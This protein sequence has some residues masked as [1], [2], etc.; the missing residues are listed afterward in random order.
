M[1]RGELNLTRLGAG[2][3]FLTIGLSFNVFFFFFFFYFYVF[4]CPPPFF[5][6]PLVIKDNKTQWQYY[7]AWHIGYDMIL[8]RYY[9]HY[10]FQSNFFPRVYFGNAS[11]L[12]KKTSLV[13]WANYSI[14]IP[15][16][17]LLKKYFAGINKIIWQRCI[18]QQTQLFCETLRVHEKTCRVHHLATRWRSFYP[19]EFFTQIKI[20][21]SKWKS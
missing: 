16:L 8:P 12:T 15:N 21:W 3:A 18:V 4:N 6:L 7:S 17:L 20:K 5:K 10:F 9:S 11:S 2:H 13:C 19:S 14:A 1:E